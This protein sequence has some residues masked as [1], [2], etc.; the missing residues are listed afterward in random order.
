VRSASEFK[1]PLE[2]IDSVNLLSSS[3]IRE[4]SCSLILFRAIELQEENRYG[5]HGPAVM[6]EYYVINRTN[7]RKEKTNTNQEGIGSTVHLQYY[8]TDCPKLSVGMAN[9]T[10]GDTTN[11][12][13]LSDPL[14]S[15][16]F[17]VNPRHVQLS[18]HIEQV[19]IVPSDDW[20]TE[21]T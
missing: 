2:E 16:L 6:K 4:S 18:V 10:C 11:I 5:I 9:N 1:E 17:V 15:S 14:S 3:F 8:R 20:S 12:H 21:R 13:V 19:I 7:K